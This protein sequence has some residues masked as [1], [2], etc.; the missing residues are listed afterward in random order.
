MKKILKYVLASVSVLAFAGCSDFLTEETNGQVFDNVLTSQE[1]L[2]AALTGAYNGLNSPWAHGLCNGTFQQLVAGGDDIYCP[3]SDANGTQLDRC[4]VTDS[5]GSFGSTWNGLYKVVLGANTV[6]NNYE[7][8]SGSTETIPVIAGEAYFL[9]AYA[10]FMLV[11]LW[12]EIPLIKS[13]SYDEAEASMGVSSEADVYALIEE[14]ID[15]AVSLLGDTRRNN[16]IGRP[17]RLVARALRAEIYLT[18]AGWPLKKD[19]YYAKAAEEAKAVLDAS[20]GQGVTLAESCA[21][22]FINKEE[23][24][25][26]TSE[27]LFVI[28]ASTTDYIVFYGAWCEPSEIGGWD[29][30]FAEVGFMEKFPEG[31]RK[32]ATFYTEYTKKGENG[33]PDETVSW[34]NWKQKHPGILKLMKYPQGGKNNVAN[35]NSILPAHML[36]LS[37]TALTYAEA[38]A[39]SQE[40]SQDAYY[41]LNRIRTRAGLSEY[42]GLSRQEFIDAV[43]NE[44]AWELAGEGVRWFDLLRLELVEKSF[45]DKNPEYDPTMLNKSTRYTFPLPA[46]E[47]LLNPNLKPKN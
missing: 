18:E 10:Y 26:I 2:E 29:I 3:T 23:E 28:P 31:P 16:E 39:R 8:C 22:L 11:R 44:R 46:S 14:D 4:G 45:E 30:I 12:G 19:G 43:V 38:E 35:C 17:N 40:P 13:S 42:Q 27:D 37:Q 6:I 7:K 47:T 9:R 33:A 1:G 24:N 34:Q 32:D 15:K 41:W 25:C 36:R 21:D 5:N 20:E